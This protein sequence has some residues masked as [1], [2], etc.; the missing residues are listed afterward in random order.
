MQS[1]TS[2]RVVYHAVAAEEE[3]EQRPQPL[4]VMCYVIAFHFLC[5]VFSLWAVATEHLDM[6]YGLCWELWLAWATM[7]LLSSALQGVYF[8]IFLPAEA[9]SRIP[10]FGLAIVTPVVPVL[11]EPLDT[12]K[13]WLFVGLALSQRRLYERQQLNIALPGLKTWLAFAVALVGLGILCLSGRYLWRHHSEELA[14]GLLPVRAACYR[15]HDHTLLAKLSSPAKLAVAITEDLPQ[16][17]LQSLF[18]LIYGGSATQYFFIVIASLKALACLL[19]RATILENEGRYSD[20][21]EA[22][23]F[24]YRL[25]SGM[26][27]SLLGKRSEVVLQTRHN[28]ARSLSDLG[29]HA[30]AL[31]MLR[32]VLADQQQVLE[33]THPDT[34][35]TQ[36][37]LAL[38]LSRFGRHAEALDVQREV[39][40]ARQ[41]V[42]GDAHPD[43]LLIHSMLATF[44]SRLGRHAEAFDVQ[45]EVLSAQ[46]V[47]LG[48]DHLDTLRTQKNLA[49]SLCRLHR[50]AEAVDVYRKVAAA[51][52]QVLGA[53]LDMHQEVLAALTQALGVTHP[54]TLRS[55]GRLAQSLADLRR[56]EE[57]LEQQSLNLKVSP[58]NWRLWDVLAAQQRTLG[59]AH[60]D[61]LR[62]QSSI[63]TSLSALGRHTEALKIH[64]EVLAARQQTLGTAHPDT[65]MTQSSLVQCLRDLGRHSDAVEVE[66]SPHGQN[67]FVSMAPP[68]IQPYQAYGGGGGGGQ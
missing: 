32:E 28:L 42:L 65:Q 41:E 17:A 30:E 61:S 6:R 2:S 4:P 15:R 45:R 58:A 31:D 25:M 11:G 40:S 20:A 44:L 10:E 48:D 54:D 66:R 38:V 23:I 13:D 1:R 36:S 63:A 68:N 60:S 52:Q 5:A 3:V 9:D 47:V 37:Y 27:S 39:L 7:M 64:K 29:R 18:V 21:N 46:Q 24:L 19:L 35:L 51:Y 16:A 55:Q 26:G 59:A 49:S 43:T 8:T 57:A 50:H 12:F 67:K 34:L 14:A 33:A 56:H 62:T 22:R 53:A